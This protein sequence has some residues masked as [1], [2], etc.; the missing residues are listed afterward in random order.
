VK[1]RKKAQTGRS[2]ELASRGS[3]SDAGYDPLGQHLFALAAGSWIGISLLKFGNPVIF[4]EMITAPQSASE[5]LFTS[6]PVSWG[7][8]VLGVVLLFSV[9]WVRPV[10]RKGLWPAVLL[11]GWFL[12]Q[13]ISGLRTVDPRLTNPTLMHFAACLISFAVGAWALARIEN[14]RWFWIPI[15]GC[16]FYV[17]LNGFDQ[18]HG[19]LESVRKAFYEQPGWQLYPR[20]YILKIQSDRIFSTMVYPN[21]LAAVILMFLPV[22]LWQTWNLTVR[23]PR[24]L[25]G[26]AVGLFLYLGLGCLYWTGSKGG[27]LVALLICAVLLLHLE[28][29]RK[30]KTLLVVGGLLLGLAVFFIRFST[31]FQKGA[32][33]VGARVIY[34]EG[35]MRIAKANPIFG[36]GPGTFSVAFRKVK[37]PEAEMARLTH[38]D[39]LE[40]ASDSGVPGFLGFSGFIIGS[41]GI[42]YRKSITAGRQFFLMWLGLLGCSL[43]SL[44][45]FSLYIPALAWPSFLWFGWLLG[46]EEPRPAQR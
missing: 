44:I 3:Q 9:S 43:Q 1:P 40:Q 7:Y 22:V 45:E 24:V 32:T 4:D 15:L 21:A 38:N 25:R 34:W 8:A 46:R 39:Y 35:A 5:F 29:S 19:G 6:W 27:W 2:P 17:L 30:A 13:L 26:V 42:L 33:S 16:F 11:L 18:R 28:F 14:M 31:Y 10:F 12:W 36:T 37:P 41:L 23:W 20:D